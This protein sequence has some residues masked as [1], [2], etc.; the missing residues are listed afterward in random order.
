MNKKKDL[1]KLSN[2]D[3]EKEASRLA[4]NFLVSISKEKPNKLE[5]SDYLD[6]YRKVVSEYYRRASE[7]EGEE[8]I[9]KRF[10]DLHR[11]IDSYY[12]HYI[13][14]HVILGYSKNKE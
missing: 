11:A 9:G 6:N 1:E 8:N 12:E 3:L 2:S 4:G 5:V 13:Y 14:N 7:G 10:Q